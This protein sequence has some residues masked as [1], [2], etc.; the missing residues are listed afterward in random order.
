MLAFLP[1]PV[2]G[3][4][5]MTLFVLNLVFWIVPFYIVALAKLLIPNKAWRLRCV[6]GLEA[7]GETWIACNSLLA[8]LH[9]SEW[10][11]DGDEGLE[12]NDW[13]LV[14][15]NHQAWVDIFVL[16]YVFNRRIPFLKFFI[17]KNLIWVP[18]LGL[19]W[20]ALDMPFMHRHSKEKLAENPDLRQQDL[21]ATRRA[22]EHFRD[23][24]TSVINFVEGTRFTPAKHDAQQSP[25]KNLLKPKTGGLAF[26][27][28][29]MGDVIHTYLDVTIVYPKVRPTFWDL[30]CGRLWPVIVRVDQHQIPARFQ[31]AD[32]LSDDAFRAEFRDWLYEIWARKDALIDSLRG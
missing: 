14:S 20:W 7:I 6:A 3:A 23:L 28:G 12:R 11:I 25:F 32:Y 18:L 17:K 31:G 22:C 5:S 19:A 21:E 8:R 30:M 10:D 24:P 27:L 1:A 13:Y 26:V 15:S 29:T 4:I 2:L 9:D 16:Q